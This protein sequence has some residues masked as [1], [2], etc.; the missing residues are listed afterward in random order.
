MSQVFHHVN[1]MSFILRSGSG[2]A[3]EQ[4]PSPRP[5]EKIPEEPVSVSPDP[6]L[7]NGMD[8][9]E[10]PALGVSGASPTAAE[11]D[12]STT[13]AEG[14][15]NES[16]ATTT[17]TLLSEDVISDNHGQEGGVKVGHSCSVCVWVY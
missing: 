10:T 17:E 4:P 12:T 14:G 7:T 5:M 8:I 2:A 13:V 3:I 1:T 15:L 6:P 11:A 9:E 16:F